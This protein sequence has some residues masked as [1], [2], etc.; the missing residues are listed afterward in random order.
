MIYF[1]R[2]GSVLYQ[3]HILKELKGIEDESCHML[4][5]SPPYWGLRD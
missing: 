4:V 1:K 3:G 5:T 2:S